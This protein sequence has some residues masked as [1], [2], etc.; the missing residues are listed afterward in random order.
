[1]G[2]VEKGEKL[3]RGAALGEIVS[4][5]RVTLIRGEEEEE[6]VIR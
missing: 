6:G 5:S 4:T 3:K 1:L 2:P